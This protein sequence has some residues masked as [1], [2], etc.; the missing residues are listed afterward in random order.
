MSEKIGFASVRPIRSLD[1]LARKA[2]FTSQWQVLLGNI[3]AHTF[4]DTSS[5]D[6]RPELS[7]TFQ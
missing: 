4:T 3:T 1:L 2:F 6:Y 7:I 5:R